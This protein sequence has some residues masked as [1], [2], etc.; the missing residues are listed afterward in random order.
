MAGQLA[1][2]AYP[3]QNSTYDEGETAPGGP[4]THALPLRKSSGLRSDAEIKLEY[5]KLRDAGMPLDSMK[6]VLN[7]DLSAVRRPAG[8]PRIARAS[9]PPLRTAA[10]AAAGAC[11]RSAVGLSQVNS[12]QV[13]SSARP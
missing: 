10:R 5:S 13:K 7:E 6:L 1:A 3:W 11:L 12:S 9:A 2:T 4:D 8:R